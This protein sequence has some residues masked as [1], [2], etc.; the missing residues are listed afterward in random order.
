LV[1]I[2]VHA[3]DGLKMNMM[4]LS[5]AGSVLL[6]IVVVYLFIVLSK[7]R[8]VT[9][10]DSS[11]TAQL[12]R[13]SVITDAEAEATR[14]V[15]EAMLNSQ[16]MIDQA[17]A[18]AELLN[19][20]ATIL[21]RNANAEVIRLSEESTLQA[22]EIIENAQTK[23]AYLN[24]EARSLVSN[25]E[26]RVSSLEARIKE[27]RS[28]YSEKKVIYDELEKAISIYRE[29]AEFAEMG[30]FEPHF[31][32]DTS[33]EFKESIRKNRSKQKDMI[34]VKSRDGA[35]WCGT[36]WTVHNSRAEGKKMTN[37][38]INL[39]AR[40]FN[41]ECDAAIANCTFK[42]WSIMHD[43]I[44]ASFDKINTLNE[45]NDVHISQKYLEL[46]K[47]ELD[48]VHSYKMKKQAEKEEQREI[49]AQMAEERKAQ[50]EIERAIK[51][52]EAEEVRAQKALDKARKEMEAKLA[53]MT[54]EQ[55]ELY[56]TKIDAL[57]DALTEAEL[58]GQKALS[59]AQ[60][61]KRGHVYV[62]S[63]IGS[64]GDDVFKIGMTRRLDPQDRVD[65]LGS[66]SVPFLFDVHAMIHSDD[67][68]AL[69]NALHQ[70]FDN[71][72][73]NMVNRRKEFFNVSLKDIKEA[74]Y[75]IAG[76]DVDFVETV[77]A[78]HYYETLA[79]RKKKDEVV[80]QSSI[81]LA[82]VPRFADAI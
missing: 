35:I 38:A 54:E 10:S 17:K 48:L 33:E 79:I 29:D 11:K 49:R 72:R 43:R 47:K 27:L 18:A 1:L 63:N 13:Y 31:D 30:A 8:K 50:L 28:S 55:A 44:Q 21:L 74:V 16:H 62:I 14:L 12:E 3:W 5:V 61:T 81:T 24:D 77:V 66:A 45:V 71:Q 70:H 37:R 59:M 53:K 51:E 41:G 7:L 69:E 6:L 9:A 58:K 36:D 78:Q 26:N 22:K 67:A 23:A 73:T 75:K 39:T 52:A 80:E 57:Q 15:E 42:N 2:T 25:A 4:Y 56:Q 19:E 68:P 20:E 40:A 76:N 34:R 32:F 46:K 64:F 65:E 82:S 60:Q